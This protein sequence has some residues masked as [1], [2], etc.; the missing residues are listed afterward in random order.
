MYHE[1]L[2]HAMKFGPRI[3]FPSY[4]GGSKSDKIFYRSRRNIAE[5]TDNN[6][7]NWMIVDYDI[8]IHLISDLECFGLKQD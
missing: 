8:E 5:Q 6:S 1:L 4:A 2:Y 7:S 3:L